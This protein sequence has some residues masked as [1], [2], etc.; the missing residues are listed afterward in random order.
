M[1]SNY[2]R[3]ESVILDRAVADEQLGGNLLLVLAH[4]QFQHAQFRGVRSFGLGLF[5]LRVA[6]R[7]ERLIETGDRRADKMLPR[8]DGPD[9]LGYIAD[10][11]VLQQ[12]PER[13][14]FRAS[15][16]M[17][18]SSYIVRKMYRY[19]DAAA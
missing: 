12:I 15:L 10:G 6:L 14:A 9:A 3:Y 13:A 11:A 7:R 18:S 16:N 4:D 5:S 2:D 17:R 1:N 19:P 8:S